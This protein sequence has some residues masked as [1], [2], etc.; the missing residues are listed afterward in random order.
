MFYR[1]EYPRVFSRERPITFDGTLNEHPI[2]SSPSFIDVDLSSGIIW[3]FAHTLEFHNIYSAV[4]QR[5]LFSLR[6]VPPHCIVVP[7]ETASCIF[8]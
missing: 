8:Q 1:R 6:D 4:Q 7:A 5:R 2:L 3:E